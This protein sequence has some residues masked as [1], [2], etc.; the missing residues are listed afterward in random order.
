MKQTAWTGPRGSVVHI[1]NGSAKPP[2]WALLLIDRV[3][4]RA[5]RRSINLRWT[6]S[7]RGGSGRAYGGALIAVHYS[8]TADR[9]R[10]IVIHELAHATS[11]G[12][13]HDARFYDRLVAIAKDE[14]CL[15][16]VRREHTTVHQKAPFTR[17]VARAKV[18]ER[19]DGEERLGYQPVAAER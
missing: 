4:D 14:G 8:G 17:A 16:M 7:S 13:G 19:W 6:R 2:R 15:R 10:Y 5:G 9:D 18:A 1:G 12:R 3:L 11:R